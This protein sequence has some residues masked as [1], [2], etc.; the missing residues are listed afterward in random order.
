MSTHQ[1]SCSLHFSSPSSSFALLLLLDPFSLPPLPLPH[2]TFPSPSPTS[3]TVLLL[4]RPPPSRPSP[5]F[6]S[7]F[8][9]SSSPFLLLLTDRFTAA[10]ARTRGAKHAQTNLTCYRCLPWSSSSPSPLFSLLLTIPFHPFSS[11]F[12]SYSSRFPSY[13][14]SFSPPHTIPLLLR[15]AFLTWRAANARRYPPTLLL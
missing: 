10:T 2:L 11:S 8:F 12:F 3:I 13:A 9:S 6:S 7:S 15:V 5:S 14:F 1:V 4:I